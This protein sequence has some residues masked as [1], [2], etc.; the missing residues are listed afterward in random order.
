MKRA[1]FVTGTD[2]GVGKTRVASALLRWG[3]A[4]GLRTLGLKPLATG[5]EETGAGLRN[6]DARALHALSTVTVPYD[7]VNPFCFRE[8]MAPHLA[9]RRVGVRL[10][11]ASVAAHVRAFEPLCDLLVVEG[12]GGLRVPLNET[13]DLSDLANALGYPVVLV[14]GLRLGCLN[15]ALLSARDLDRFGA[16]RRWAWV[17]NRIDP[18]MLDPEG[19]RETLRERLGAPML[20]EQPHAAPAE[21]DAALVQ[22]SGFEAWLSYPLGATDGDGLRGDGTFVARPR[23]RF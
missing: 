21:E 20:W 4:Q 9:A 17:A 6:D 16:V 15:H 23:G 14:V 11:V 3:R 10:A 5:A 1:L 12:V 8:P 22:T 2:T 7:S 18:Q 13:E 19:N